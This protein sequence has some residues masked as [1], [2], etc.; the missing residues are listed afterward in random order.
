MSVS[1]VRGVADTH[2]RPHP[3]PN[4]S[5]AALLPPHRVRVEQLGP[6]QEATGR[7]PS[8]SNAFVTVHR[9]GPS[10]VAGFA[11]RTRPTPQPGV[12]EPLGSPVVLAC[13]EAG[14]MVGACAGA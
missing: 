13:H 4:K 9:H 7:P 8:A 14:W 12:A 6:T 5:Q 3:S 2:H 1:Q 10:D 11:I